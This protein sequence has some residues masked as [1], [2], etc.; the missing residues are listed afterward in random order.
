M[1]HGNHT[2]CGIS[3]KPLMALIVLVAHVKHNY[4][5]ITLSPLVRP[6]KAVVLLE[7]ECGPTHLDNFR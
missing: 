6:Y 5:K 2:A 4:I 1:L 7:Y 3:N